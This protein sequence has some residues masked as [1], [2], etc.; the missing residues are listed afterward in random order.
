LKL[1]FSNPS[2]WFVAFILVIGAS[3]LGISPIFVRLSEIGPFSTAF[4]RSAL[5]IPLIFVFFKITIKDIK[6]SLDHHILVLFLPGFF[7]GIDHAAWHHGIM[8]T[9]VANATLFACMAP[10]FVVLYGFI[11][12]SWRVSYKYLFSLLIVIIGSAILLFNSLE[13]SFSNF[14]GDIWSLFAG[15]CYGAYL[16]STGIMRDKKVKINLIIFYSTLSSAFTLFVITFFSGETYIPLTLNGWIII[17]LI[18]LI[19]QV[20]G[21]GLI[22]WALGKVKTSLASLTLMSEPLAA[23]LAASIIL[24]EFIN[25]NQIIGGIII[26]LGIIFAQNNSDLKRN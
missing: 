16:I 15:A 13:L 9:S 19:S 5:A 4:W 7:L 26:V 6:E 12:F 1:N 14:I 8:L 24:F 2:V 25:L 11:L 21:I 20:I 17:F 3:C 22:T 18:A 10:I 23:T